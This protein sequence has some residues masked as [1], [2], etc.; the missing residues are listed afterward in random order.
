MLRI[1]FVTCS[2]H[3]G[4]SYFYF[5]SGS[6]KHCGTIRAK[7]KW[8]K[9]YSAKTTT[10]TTWFVVSSST[11]NMGRIKRYTY[12]N[13]P[14]YRNAHGTVAKVM[15]VCV[16]WRDFP[17]CLAL[18]WTPGKTKLFWWN[19]WV[20]SPFPVPVHDSFSSIVPPSKAQKDA[21]QTHFLHDT[22]YALHTFTNRV[23][24]LTVCMYSYA[25]ERKWTIYSVQILYFHLCTH[26]LLICNLIPMLIWRWCF[27]MFNVLS[28]QIMH[29]WPRVRRLNV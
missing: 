2:L 8:P 12:Q 24:T 23:W 14:R 15:L 18:L 26:I 9:V 4:K 3:V 22:H 21:V 16:E 28:V 10:T 1:L 20:E 19:L 17:I 29:L 7:W 5:T 25:T 11:V 6:Q 13:L 27:Y